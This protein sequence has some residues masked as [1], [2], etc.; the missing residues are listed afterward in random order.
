MDPLSSAKTAETLPAAGGTPGSLPGKWIAAIKKITSR[1]VL[2]KIHLYIAL[3][4]TGK[5]VLVAVVFL[6]ILDEIGVQLDASGA[7]TTM[8]VMFFKFN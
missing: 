3:W 6:S 1:T 8:G 5:F 4:R 7:S 2:L